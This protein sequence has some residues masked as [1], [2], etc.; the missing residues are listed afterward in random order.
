MLK[1][2]LRGCSL[3]RV[4]DVLD[5][6]NFDIYDV[7]V[8]ILWGFIFLL[9]VVVGIGSVV[10]ALAIPIIALAS[11]DAGKLLLYIP[12]LL[13]MSICTVSLFGIYNVVVDW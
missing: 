13:V 8:F 1:T 6:E 9:L 10:Y 12:D 5:G 4:K 2:I 11:Y 7:P 3:N